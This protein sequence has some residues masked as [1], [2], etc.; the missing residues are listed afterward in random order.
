M[1]EISVQELKSWKE[2]AKDFQLIDVRDPFENEWRNIDGDSIPMG[3]ILEN[4]DKINK[5]GDVVLHCNSGNRVAA[6]ID[7]LERKHGFTNLM[8]LTGGFEAWCEAYEP[9]WLVY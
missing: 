6:V 5:T 8:N 4:L 2:S 7:I 9:S 3:S 1:R